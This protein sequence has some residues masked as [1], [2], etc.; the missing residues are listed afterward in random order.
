[1]RY[2]ITSL[3]LTFVAVTG[4]SSLNAEEPAAVWKLSG[5]T[6][7]A[8]SSSPDGTALGLS[9]STGVFPKQYAT[10]NGRGDHVRVPAHAALQLGT[11]DFTLSLWVHAS[12]SADDDLGDLLSSFD[13]KTRTGFHL[14][15]R[16]NSGVTHSQ[17]NFRQLQF[18][19]DAGTDPIFTDEG[20]PGRAVFG[21]S[22]AVH[23]DRLYV[24]T[25]EAGVDQAGH[26]FAY[27]GADK[28]T[29][30]GSPDKA[31]SITGMAAFDG[32]L[33]V[34]SG[35]YRLGGSSLQ[36]SE[37]PN[38]G[39]RIF[40]LNDKSQ[41]QEVGHLPGVE[42]V[43]GMVNYKGKLYVS[44]LYKPAAFFRYDGDQ[45]WTPLSLPNGKRVEALGVF[46]GSL[47]ASG[48]DEGHVYRFDGETWTDMGQVGEAANTQTYAFAA[49]QGKLQVATWA[50]GK[51]FEWNNAQWIDRGRTGTELEVMG[52]LVHNGSFYGGTLPLGQIYRYEG[53]EHWELLKQLDTTPDVKY[54]RL[55]TMAQYRGKLF[56]TTLPSGHIW[57]METGLCTTWDREFP[58]G[59]HHIAAQRAGKELRLFVDGELVSK[60]TSSAATPLNLSNDQPWQIGAGSGDFFHGAM[61]DVQLH[62]YALSADEIRKLATKP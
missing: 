5:D 52:M 21:Q 16:T 28:W 15:L 26:V 33:Y 13:P 57:S 37:N 60:A 48:Y 39:G 32:H 3:L 9:Y 61:A 47:W 23:D 19:V 12:D 11:S 35:K 29:D 44:S 43:G 14:S 41:W 24:G 42:A 31:N 18:G 36:E 53:G 59:W 38:L 46:D 20:R 40:R 55:W 6:K 49:Y 8:V 50:T 30:L 7:N 4:F 45:R 25:C 51:V 34:G 62:R 54:R 17:A 22:M 56:N 58:T 1:M 10:L 2:Q 27:E